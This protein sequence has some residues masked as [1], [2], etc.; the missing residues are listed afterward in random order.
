MAKSLAFWQP[1]RVRPIVSMQ[2]Q[3]SRDE[4][5]AHRGP[6]THLALSVE[7]LAD[8]ETAISMYR[9]LIANG[10]PSFLL[11]SA[12]G[13]ET[14]GRYSFIGIDPVAVFS[15][16]GGQGEIVRGTSREA[17]A[18]DDPLEVLKRLVSAYRVGA[19]P[20]LPR[21]QGGAVGWLSYDC[22]RYFEP[23]ARPKTGSDL[24]GCFLLAETIVIVDHLRH[25]VSFVALVPLAGDRSQSYD[26]AVDRLQRMV[27]LLSAPLPP[28][29]PFF[30]AASRLPPA[31]CAVPDH[32]FE[33]AVR[34]AKQAI[35]AGEIFQVV[36][37]RR[38]TVELSLSPFEI[39][40]AFRALNPSPYMFLLELGDHA[41]VGAS[42]EV[43]VQVDRG[44]VLLRP[45]AGTRR[46]GADAAEDFDLERDLLSDHK[47]L[48]E[49][50]MLV[51]LGRNDVGR[52]AETG[53]VRVERPLHIERYSHVMHIVS[54]VHGRLRRGLD[55]FDAFRACFPAGTVSGAPKIRAMELIGKLEPEP[56]GLYS[57][58]VG[59]FD[60]AGNMDTCIAIRTMVVRPD[61]VE[62]Q[63][64]AGIVYDSDPAK[65]LEETN[66]KAKGPLTALAIAEE[67]SH[68]GAHRR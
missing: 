55:A 1:W 30:P 20:H 37:S 45:I 54:D 33:A 24:E 63:A 11:E 48:A 2:V 5:L 67:L 68:G 9:K 14:F 59:Y 57:G 65:E 34:E 25:R 47:E 31:K 21:L 38:L 4:V 29:T 64:G 16:A 28:I 6:E 26:E 44:E 22:I 50:R 8:V 12:E 3:P 15:F 61:R 17:V 36:L 41:V 51:D 10:G 7:L 43:L 42:P 27:S 18:F 19:R 39:Y 62:I 46:R 23:A 40:R 60:F 66:N 49:H 32:V 58:A 56:R 52:I 35:E 13:G 53:S